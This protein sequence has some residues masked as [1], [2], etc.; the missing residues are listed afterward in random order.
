MPVASLANFVAAARRPGRKLYYAIKG[1]MGDATVGLTAI[2]WA[3]TDVD[4]PDD[5]LIPAAIVELGE[6]DDGF[7]ESNDALPESQTIEVSILRSEISEELLA[8]ATSGSA[9]L[10]EYRNASLY[11][12]ECQL[13]VGYI[14]ADGTWDERPVTPTLYCVTSPVISPTTVRLTLGVNDEP[15]LGPSV[16]AWTLDEL[17]AGTYADGWEMDP[18]G[19]T[20]VN[21]LSSADW[22]TA[23]GR[24]L[25]NRERVVSWAYNRGPIPLINASVEGS[26]PL[27]LVAFVGTQKP[28]LADFVGPHEQSNS[29]PDRRAME[30][31][32]GE[33][34]FFLGSR[35]E[36]VRQNELGDFTHTGKTV[37][38]TLDDK[39]GNSRTVWLTWFEFSTLERPDEW[40]LLPPPGVVLSESAGASKSAV[41]LLRDII[42]THS[43]LGAAAIDSAEWDDLDSLH[44]TEESFAGIINSSTPLREIGS[45]IAEA[46]LLDLRIGADDLLHGQ[47]QVQWSRLDLTTIDG[48]DVPSLM[49]SDLLMDDSDLPW[50]ETLPLGEG[51]RGAPATILSVEWSS[52]QLSFWGRLPEQVVVDT[53]LKLGRR[54]EARV[55]GDWIQADKSNDTLTRLA[56]RR[57]QVWR[58]LSGPAVPWVAAYQPGQFFFVEYPDGVA[59]DGLGYEDRVMRLERRRLAPGDER[60]VITLVDYGKLQ[61]LMPWVLDALSEWERNAATAAANTLTLANGAATVQA[62]AAMA[63][64]KVGDSVWITDSSA[65]AYYNEHFR[66]TAVVVATTKWTVQHGDGTAVA[67]PGAKVLAAG[68]W[69]IVRTHTSPD[70]GASFRDRYGR[71][72]D[73]GTGEFS[74][75]DPG[76]ELLD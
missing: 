53:E 34:L 61:D 40:V 14:D 74:N 8:G 75:G 35:A 4:H 6:Y 50:T 42:E 54:L 30:Q 57:A 7:P 45:F 58:R 16:V 3:T 55:P 17:I 56:G 20:S 41:G 28:E 51:E 52:E 10:L 5:G 49:V 25:L 2:A 19:D 1:T 73:E 26:S 11:N 67:W 76:Y 46:I 21:T 38:L 24:M 18:I 32:A 31:H 71:L 65:A 9:R 44:N 69:R 60:C 43:E 12:L 63:D 13:F 47:F 68:T 36:P 66:I 48:V 27:V 72:C 33:F 64:V 37:Q 39:L 70:A 15:I 62:G 22:D 23:K 59:A 29:V